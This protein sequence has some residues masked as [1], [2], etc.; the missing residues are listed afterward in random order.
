MTK[1]TPKEDPRSYRLFARIGQYTSL[2]EGDYLA[3]R[4]SK[5]VLMEALSGEE[6]L[7]MLLENFSEYE[8]DLLSMT[9]RTTLFSEESWSSI[10]ARIHRIDRRVLNTLSSARLYLD[11]TRH[12]ISAMW[13]NPST[14][15]TE[16]E[17]QTAAEYDRFLGYRVMEALR[18][19]VQHRGL[20]VHEL[21]QEMWWVTNGDVERVRHS[22]QP[23]LRPATLKEEGGF[24]QKVL[25]EI[26]AHEA[27][28]IRPLV[29]EYIAGLCRVQLL[30]RELFKTSVEAAEAHSAAVLDQLQKPDGTPPVAAIAQQMEKG[31]VTE[32]IQ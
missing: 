28:D 22:L 18:N 26:D 3:I 12:A 27:L 9:L 7:D 25:V 24:K 30:M 14:E 29:R 23:S 13:G 1:D 2:T 15:M 16:F 6:K 21:A 17:R 32:E 31:M 10:K 5:K 20:S 19:Y 8:E 4:Q 11:Q